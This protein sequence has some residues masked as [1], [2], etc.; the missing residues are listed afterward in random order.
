LGHDA[1]AI[2]EDL[3]DGAVDPWRQSDT[4]KRLNLTR[5]IDLAGDRF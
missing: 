5:N 3:L 2:D 1:A 4:Q